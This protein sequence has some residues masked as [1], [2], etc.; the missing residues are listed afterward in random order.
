MAQ[1][2]VILGRKQVCGQ[3]INWGIKFAVNLNGK[4][5]VF[6]PDMLASSGTGLFSAA[7]DTQL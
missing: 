4:S 7:A 5:M 1:H 2:D 3:Q 6:L